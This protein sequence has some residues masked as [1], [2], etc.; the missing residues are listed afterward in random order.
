MTIHEPVAPGLAQALAL[1]P[2]L[3]VRLQAP[4]GPSTLTHIASDNTPMQTAGNPRCEPDSGPRNPDPPDSSSSTSTE[5]PCMKKIEGATRRALGKTAITLSGRDL[6][7]H[8][9]HPDIMDLPE[10]TLGQYFKILVSNS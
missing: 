7:P 2:T 5:N 1:R 6:P 4:A 8:L 9:Q 3:K 10:M